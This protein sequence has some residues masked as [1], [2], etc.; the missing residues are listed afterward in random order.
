[1]K[2]QTLTI[3]ITIPIAISIQGQ[4]SSMDRRK[5]S[6]LGDVNGMKEVT[7]ATMP[8]GSEMS[9]P[10]KAKGMKGNMRTIP[11]KFPADEASS[12][13]APSPTKR[14]ANNKY[15]NMAINKS[16]SNSGTSKYSSKGKS[17]FHRAIG[18]P[19]PSQ[20]VT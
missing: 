13:V 20:T 19:I 18:S 11:W 1:M 17:I 8:F 10:I 4:S 14:E 12:M 6:T 15:P 16:T 2:S 7:L 9:G 5:I 3:K